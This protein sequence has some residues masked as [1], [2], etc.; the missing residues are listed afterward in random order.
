MCDFLN[1]LKSET[2]TTVNEYVSFTLTDSGVL[3]FKL[4]I[5]KSC[6]KQPS[7]YPHPTA[8]NK[9]VHHSRAKVFTQI[10]G[11]IF[12]RKM[13]KVLCCTTC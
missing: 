6:Q 13:E 11:N 10:C 5:Q 4:L 2:I 8:G 1:N 7:Y 3:G 9:F 12:T